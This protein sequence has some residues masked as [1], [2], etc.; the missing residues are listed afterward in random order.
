M[1]GAFGGSYI[2]YFREGAFRLQH[3][4]SNY[5]LFQHDKGYLHASENGTVNDVQLE[6]FQIEM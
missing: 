3:G 6:V 2:F 1:Y 4:S 5:Q